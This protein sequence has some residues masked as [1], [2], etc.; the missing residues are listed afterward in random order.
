MMKS[1]AH[2]NSAIEPPQLTDI[3]DG[4][5]LALTT[6]TPLPG[7][8]THARHVAHDLR[9]VAERL[10]CDDRA[11]QLRALGLDATAGYGDRRTE[12]IHL[13]VACVSIH[14][15]AEGLFVL[16]AEAAHRLA[17]R[18]AS[19]MA[20]PD[21]IER[22]VEQCERPVLSEASLRSLERD[23]D[24]HVRRVERGDRL[25]AKGWTEEQIRESAP[26]AI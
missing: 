3:Q 26:G 15:D 4:L 18:L 25:R 2:A 11:A 21:A 10:D 22:T 23:A 14:S 19:G 13:V 24:A 17:Q 9:V 16:D 1:Y 12:R 5:Y 7:P 20:L 8:F 6:G